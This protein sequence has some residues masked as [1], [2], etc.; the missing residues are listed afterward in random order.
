M[1]TW[2]LLTGLTAW[3]CGQHNVTLQAP[4]NGDYY[5]V[6]M[7]GPVSLSDVEDATA[8]F[9]AQ[10]TEIQSGVVWFSS[11]HPFYCPTGWVDWSSEG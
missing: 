10:Y 3:P 5:C 9:C 8:D 1:L 2:I 7:S 6:E 11:G 4:H